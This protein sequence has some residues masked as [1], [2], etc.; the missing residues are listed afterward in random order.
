[1][2]YLL[3]THTFLWWIADDQKLSQKVNDIIANPNNIIYISP[4]SGHEIAIKSRIGKLKIS[5]DPY[6]FI[7]RQIEEN[8]FKE[9]KISLL[10]TLSILKLPLV[11]R[12]PFDRLLI[13]QSIT[14]N[15]PILS[16]DTVFKD[17]KVKVIW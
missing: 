2:K 17:Y 1:M 15:I 13:A 14:E 3:D 11:H 10:H 16:S 6:N 5:K 8:F 9:L 12:D 4:A 7:F